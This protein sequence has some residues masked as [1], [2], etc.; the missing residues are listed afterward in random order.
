MRPD[1]TKTFFPNK[2]NCQQNDKATYWKEENI[3]KLFILEGVNI[4]TI[5]EL[6]QINIKKIQIV[7]TFWSTIQVSVTLIPEPIMSS[8]Y[9]ISINSRCICF[10]YC[11]L[12][13]YKY[14][15]RPKSLS[16]LWELVMDREA[17]RAAIHGVAKSRTWLSDWTE[18]KPV[19]LSLSINKVSAFWTSF[20]LGV[21]LR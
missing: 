17:W 5:Q 6:L 16:E 19:I 13:F 4:Q 9:K 12:K 20:F 3:C 15:I 8:Q 10:H 18:L 1:Q 21:W 2:G 11:T 14:L 7:P